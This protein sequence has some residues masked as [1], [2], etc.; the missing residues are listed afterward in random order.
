MR[1]P[2]LVVVVAV[3]ATVAARRRRAGLQASSAACWKVAPQRG[4]LKENVGHQGEELTYRIV[5][6]ALSRKAP[7]VIWWPWEILPWS[8]EVLRA[9]LPATLVV[10]G[11]D[12]PPP[13]ACVA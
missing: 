3:A 7:R 2:A 1:A 12:A 13:E 11:A 10:A 6:A 8:R 9:T 5:A 4:R